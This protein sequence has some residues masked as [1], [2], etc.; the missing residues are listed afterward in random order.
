M[1]HGAPGGEPLWIVPKEPAIFVSV[2][3]QPQNCLNN[4]LPGTF[5]RVS[6]LPVCLADQE[7]S[8][9]AIGQNIVCGNSRE[10]PV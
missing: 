3:A 2:R 4:R 10:P 1:G 6:A 9:N 7:S 5:Q 8:R